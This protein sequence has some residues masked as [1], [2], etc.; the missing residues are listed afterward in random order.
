MF[1]VGNSPFSIFGWITLLLN[2]NLLCCDIGIP[3]WHYFHI[4]IKNFVFRATESQKAGRY[5]H[6]NQWSWSVQI[7]CGVCLHVHTIVLLGIVLIKLCYWRCG[8][9]FHDCYVVGRPHMQS[10]DKNYLQVM[11]T[12]NSYD[13]KN[14]NQYLIIHSP[15]IHGQ[16]WGTQP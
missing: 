1:R 15:C 6:H 16:M 7:E 3:I 14:Y 8:R 13:F 10:K 11:L 5:S 12:L 4:L 2:P 9:V